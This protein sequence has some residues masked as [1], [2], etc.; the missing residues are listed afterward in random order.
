MDHITYP[1][2]Q[3]ENALAVIGH[4]KPAYLGTTVNMIFPREIRDNVARGFVRDGLPFDPVTQA[5]GQDMFGVSWVYE[6]AVRGSMVMPG[7]PL[8]EEVP[9]WREKLSMP[10]LEAIDWEAVKERCAPLVS[11]TEL[12]A[13]MVFTGYF[14]RLISLMDFENAAMAMVDEDCAEELHALFDALTDYYIALFEKL[15]TYCCIDMIT[16]HDDWGHQL[17]SF[18]SADTCREL[19]LPYIRRIVEACHRNGMLFDLHCCGKVENLVPLMVEAGIDKWDGQGINDLWGLLDRYGDRLC[20][21]LTEKIPQM[22]PQEAERWADGI[23]TR[24]SPQ[25]G[26]NMY[27]PARGLCPAAR[28]ALARKSMAFYG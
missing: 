21:T 28:D 3:R 15:R 24:L 25:G 8:L 7:K 26:K 6:P 19:L 27:L 16:F 2:S 17:S 12:N 5:G 20:I 11:G 10:D 4:G 13:T 9:Q 23:L 1:I 18:F 22:E 14:E